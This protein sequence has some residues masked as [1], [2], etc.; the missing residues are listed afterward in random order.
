MYLRPKR[1]TVIPD[2]KPLPAPHIGCIRIQK[3]CGCLPPISRIP[4]AFTMDPV[5]V[6][7]PRPREV[8]DQHMPHI[9]WYTATSPIGDLAYFVTRMESTH[10]GWHSRSSTLQFQRLANPIARSLVTAP[11]LWRAGSNSNSS[12]SCPLSLYKQRTIKDACFEKRAKLIPFPLSEGPKG[13]GLP[14]IYPQ[15]IIRPNPW[16]QNIQ[17]LNMQR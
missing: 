2:T 6:A 9:A 5:A 16:S 14:A 17:C 15:F 8:F 13:L 1:F 10:S 12:R 7:H 11:V 4:S 3:D